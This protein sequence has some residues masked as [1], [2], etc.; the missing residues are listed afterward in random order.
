MDRIY[1]RSTQSD[2]KPKKK[3]D[4]KNRKRSLI[5]NFRVSPKEK[6]LIEKRIELSGLSRT[7]F[8]LQSCMYQKILVKG[9]IKTFD[10]I[11]AEMDEL[12]QFVNEKNADGELLDRRS[13]SESED[14]VE[15]IRMILEIL[16]YYHKK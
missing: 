10:K 12:Y 13:K 1:R 5:M 6:E 7:Q 11:R 4:E 14:R 9:N 15:A 3:K 8:F 16:R 2:G